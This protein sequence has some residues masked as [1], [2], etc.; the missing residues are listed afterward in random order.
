MNYLIRLD[1]EYT[2]ELLESVINNDNHPDRDYIRLVIL[3]YLELMLTT[4][5]FSF[6]DAIETLLKLESDQIIINTINQIVIDLRNGLNINLDN[7]SDLILNDVV[8]NRAE[9]EDFKVSSGDKVTL[10]WNNFEQILIY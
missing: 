6:L 5:L 3:D 2:H 8:I 10:R 1:H 9:L 4:D 7:L